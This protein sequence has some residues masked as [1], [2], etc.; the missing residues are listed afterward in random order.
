MAG[1]KG[2]SGGQNRKAT[3][4]L[5]N[6][7]GYRS[8]RHKDRADVVI[9]ASAIKPPQH[10]GK[11][12]KDLWDR[13]ISSIP[14]SMIT[15][16]DP[17]SLSAFCDLADVYENIRPMFM[18]DPIDKDIRIT[19]MA[20]VDRMDKLGRQFGWTP[21]SRAGL[22]LGKPKDEDESAFASLLSRMSGNN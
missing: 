3:E 9:P 16:L 19:Y 20:V 17:D 21:Q 13:V 15:K 5:K 10:L 18:A 2:R 1:V 14:P 11:A 6:E 7:G 22:Q 8:A 4:T 12:G